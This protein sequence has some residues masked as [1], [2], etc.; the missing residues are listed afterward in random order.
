MLRR[1][2]TTT[3]MTC[4]AALLCAW[5][6]A[7]RAADLAD[8]ADP[9]DTVARVA[10]AD[11]TDTVAR[12]AA[13]HVAAEAP[14]PWDPTA[15]VRDRTERDVLKAVYGRAATPRLAQ[16]LWPSVGV[17]A[18]AAH[19]ESLPEH[20]IDPADVGGPALTASVQRADATLATLMGALAGDVDEATLTAALAT[21]RDATR[22]AEVA[23][24]LAVVRLEKRLA[25]RTTKIKAPWL[26]ERAR[27]ALED[28][29]R[30]WREL[31]PAH[32]D[33]TGLIR[34]LPRY[35]EIV[36]QGGFGQMSLAERLRWEGWLPPGDAEPQPEALD[37]ALRDWQRAHVIEPTGEL[38]KPTL[39]ALGVPAHERLRS[40]LLAI[41]RWQGSP[42]RNLPSYVRVNIPAFTA[43]VWRDGELRS[44]RLA[45]VGT[46]GGQTDRLDRA[47][48]RVQ[49]NPPWWVPPGVKRVD[50]DKRA[51]L[52]P[53][54][55]KENGF[56]RFV[57]KEGHERVWMPAGP[58]NWLG[59]VI[60][61]WKGG[62]NIYI[63]DTP[64]KERFQ[65][66]RRV[67]SHGCVNLEG[68]LDLGREL[69]VGDGALTA[70]EYDRKLNAM[71]TVWID[72][73]TPFPA[74]LEY[75]TVVPDESGRL[76]FKPDLYGHD[77]REIGHIH[78]EVPPDTA[79]N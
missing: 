57:D 47:I 53:S 23:T 42:T 71:K 16:G 56:R 43:E 3:L 32:A 72:L 55:Y 48:T 9:A 54:F 12:V 62:G 34:A 79:Q 15:D 76:A 22:G 73:A 33:Y 19:I 38:D 20:A 18:L 66:V 40:L 52:N 78:V 65:A 10:A 30:W 37:Q 35:R 49:L 63:H 45:I 8:T 31:L 70:E 67:F 1:R 29:E 28:P 75:V 64:F 4:V 17:R 6:P 74:F 39:K 13:A 51:E 21:A 46:L 7:S 58:D 44:H 59:R 26:A 36:A 27:L 50:L 61:R 5:A 11:L 24:V 60:F 25:T 41:E 68:A 77:R 14:A 2:R 69:V